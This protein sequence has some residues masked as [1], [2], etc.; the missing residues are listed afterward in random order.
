M[1]RR[2]LIIVFLFCCCSVLFAQMS[3]SS[4][5]SV[6]TCGS[7]NNFYESFGHSAI[8]IQDNV[9]NI[10][11]TFNYGTFDFDEPNFYFKFITGRLP[12][13]LNVV[14]TSYF[15]VDYQE[16]GRSVE[17]RVLNLSIEEKNAI[18]QFLVENYKPENRTYAYD[19]FRDNCATRVRDVIQKAMNNKAFLDTT[20][21]GKF[22]YRD[23]YYYYTDSLLWWRFGIDL[24]L[25]M[26][27]D[28]ILTTW[29]YMYIPFDIQNQLDTIFY[30]G[31]KGGI[32]AEKVQLLQERRIPPQRTFFSPFLIF[33]LV[34]VFLCLLTFYEQ[35]KRKHYKWVDYL[36][37]SILFVISLIILFLWFGSNH[38]TM[39]Y[40]L[41]ILWLNPL[42]II[43]LIK[44]KNTPKWLLSI[45]ICCIIVS[46]LCFG[47]L[48]QT[49][50]IA[51]LPILLMILLRLFVM[52]RCNLK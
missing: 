27:T 35:K 40:N 6:L 17:E 22:S 16:E 4:K 7:G 18:Y 26:R 30:Q 23:L 20:Q 44:M 52:K 39:K 3:S 11:Y 10:D 21:Q 25:G 1:Y 24:L 37:F 28:K 14:P 49:F 41:N 13:T 42:F 15:L 5:I 48:P 47:F 38:Y 34:F 50:N 36:L 29:E 31:E 2:I 32:V 45:L 46:F 9:L 51:V 33:M 8:R 43:V 19:F 12:Y